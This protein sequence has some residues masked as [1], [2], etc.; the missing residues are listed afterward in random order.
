MHIPEP[1]RKRLI[2]LAQLLPA[3]GADTLTSLDLSRMTG[4]TD[5]TVRK[6]I[7]YLHLRGAS[8][9]YKRLELLKAVQTLLVPQDE[10]KKCYIIGCREIGRAS[11]R[12]RV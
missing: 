8:N 2:Q 1:A 3:L 9:G 7:S 11:C 6:D 4:R 12:E 5:A 10:V